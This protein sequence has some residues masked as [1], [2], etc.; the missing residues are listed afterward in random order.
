VTVQPRYSIF[1][2]SDESG[3]FI[4]DVAISHTFG[5]AYKNVSFDNPGTN[6][7]NTFTTLDFEIY[8]EENGALLVSNSVPVNSTGNLF[9]FS[10]SSFSPRFQPYQISIYGISPDGQQTY[11][12]TKQIYVLPSRTYGSA[13]KIDNL[14]EGLYVQNANNSYSGWYSI[15]PNGGYAGGGYVRKSGIQLSP[16]SAFF[17]SLQPCLW[18]TC[19]KN[20]SRLL[21]YCCAPETFTKK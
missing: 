4:V 8:N 10:F 1:L 18:S 7:S 2:D 17:G 20:V 5:Q 21:S 15:F 19:S 14:F 9:G 6:S 12:G 11:T 3:S 16:I 13:V